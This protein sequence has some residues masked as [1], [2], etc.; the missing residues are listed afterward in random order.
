MGGAAPS[1]PCAKRPPTLRP[2]PGGRGR[3]R[4]EAA[5]DERRAHLAHQMQVEV[6]VVQRGELRAQHLPRQH[7][8]PERAPA[9]VRA[10]VARAA[11]LYRTRVP[12]VRRVADHELALSGEERP[13]PGVAGGQDAIEEVISYG[14]EA[15]QIA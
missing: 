1:A 10:G 15:K 9:E 7:E 6:Q 4:R 11:V 5:L 12:G 13:V 3:A 2:R 8:V 14:R